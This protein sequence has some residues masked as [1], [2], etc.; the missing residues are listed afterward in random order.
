MLFF[1][2]S[3]NDQIRNAR[4]EMTKSTAKNLETLFAN[5]S[6]RKRETL[7]PGSAKNGTRK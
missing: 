6:S 5:S 4:D 7:A 2:E 1:L 3:T